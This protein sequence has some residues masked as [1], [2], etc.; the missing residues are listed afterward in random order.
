M[1]E[2]NFDALYFDQVG[3][4]GSKVCFNPAH[5]HPM[6]GG[7]HYL[8]NYNKLLGE[9]RKALTEIKG[10]PVPFGTEG[11]TDAFDFDLWLTIFPGGDSLQEGG[12]VHSLVCSGYGVQHGQCYRLDDIEFN[13]DDNDPAI[14][15]CA[16]EWTNGIQPIWLEAW[17]NIKSC[18]R[19]EKYF[20]KMVLCR[21]YI[22]DYNIFG[23]MVRKVKITDC[24]IKKFMWLHNS[25]KFYE[26]SQAVKTMSYNYKDKTCVVF[27]NMS[28]EKI[29]I[30]WESKGSDLGLKNKSSY[31]V[32]KFYPEGEMKLVK[33]L[34]DTIELDAF[35]TVA[36]LVY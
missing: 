31:T 24:P 2:I 5:K 10:E 15:K 16:T 3:N 29:N 34:T 13:E 7:D 22:R 12:E 27:T 26:D 21:D 17:W 9:L 28:D 11:E 32:S 8:S 6:G 20:S 33:K 35:E 14:Y 19:F 36:Y 23:E 18:P 30:T 1:K 4:T 25:E